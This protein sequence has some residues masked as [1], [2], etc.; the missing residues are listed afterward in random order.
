MNTVCLWLICRV[1]VKFIVGQHGCPIPEEDREDPY[2]CSL[3]NFTEPGKENKTSI[4]LCFY[5][6][7]GARPA[8]VGRGKKAAICCL[9]AGSTKKEKVEPRQNNRRR[10]R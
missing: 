4:Y 7:M 3:L 10:A 8:A 6:L 1:G 2:S 9:H 5:K